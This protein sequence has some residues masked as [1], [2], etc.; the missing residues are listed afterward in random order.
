M[1]GEEDLSRSHCQ[2]LSLSPLPLVFILS[3]TCIMEQLLH[4][5]QHITTTLFPN[6]LIKPQP[7]LEQLEKAVKSNTLLRK[8]VVVTCHVPITSSHARLPAVAHLIC[9]ILLYLFTSSPLHLFTSSLFTFPLSIYLLSP[10]YPPLAPSN[11]TCHIS[12]TSCKATC[13]LSCM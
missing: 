1:K 5:L 8:D 6:S 7:I 4:E 3:S 9:D 10:L 13:C 2:P 11:V 12:V